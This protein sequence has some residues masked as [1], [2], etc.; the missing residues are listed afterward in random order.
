MKY[1]MLLYKPYDIEIAKV[2]MGDGPQIKLTLFFREIDDS[3][4]K[5]PYA[6]DP[7]RNKE[8]NFELRIRKDIESFFSI[9]TTGWHFESW[10]GSLQMS[11]PYI[12]GDL[13]IEVYS[14][15]RNKR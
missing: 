9:K 13:Q 1:I 3:Y 2:L 5:N 15:E 10:N 4:L 7:I 14:D 8:D 11:A 12:V 6:A